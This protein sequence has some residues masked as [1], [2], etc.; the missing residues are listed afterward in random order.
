MSDDR[1][2][3]IKAHRNEPPFKLHWLDG[4]WL[5]AEVQRLRVADTALRAL[6]ERAKPLLEDGGG[7][8]TDF[9]AAPAGRRAF[10]LAD[11]IGVV[12]AAVAALQEPHDG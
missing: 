8:L 4:D 5:I 10:A 9:S 1:L 2:D 6:L 7:A 3:E 12:L 11:E